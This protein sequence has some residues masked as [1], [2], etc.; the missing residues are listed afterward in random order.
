MDILADWKKRIAMLASMHGKEEVIAPIFKEKLD[1]NVYPAK[2]FNTDRYGTFT[3]EIKR[4]GTQLE[5]AR[6]KARGLNIET[7]ADLV[8]ASEG[9]FAPHPY[10]PF[11]QN[12]LEIVL[13]ADF[14]NQIEVVGYYENIC[15]FAKA[16]PVTSVEE[17]LDLAQKWDFPDQGIIIRESVYKLGK[18]YK[19][20]RTAEEL[21]AVAGKLFKGIFKNRIHLETDLRAHRCPPRMKNIGQATENLTQ[22]CLSLCPNCGIPGFKIQKVEKGLPCSDC[23]RPTALI[24]LSTKTCLKCHHS[25]TTPSEK[26][27]ANPSECEFCNP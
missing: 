25:I 13:L 1:I 15:D 24:K 19:E 9:S 8:I 5:A 11:V 2:S 21:T 16:K 10:F 20:I 12:N 23:G 3:K 18:I 26:I 7:G 22:Y 4:D 14:K 17:V 27:T 6:N